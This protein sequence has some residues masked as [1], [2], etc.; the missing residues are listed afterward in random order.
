VAYLDTGKKDQAL[1]LLNKY[2]QL[3]GGSLSAKERAELEALIEKCR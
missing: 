1:V 2:K 3:Y